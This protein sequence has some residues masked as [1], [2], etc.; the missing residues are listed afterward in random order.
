MINKDIKCDKYIITYILS[1][2]NIVI[3]MKHSIYYHYI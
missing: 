3:H 2:Y 1:Y